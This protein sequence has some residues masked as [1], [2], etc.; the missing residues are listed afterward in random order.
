MS[1]PEPGRP[2]FPS[3][4]QPAFRIFPQRSY[5]PRRG[6]DPGFTPP[7]R[8]IDPGFTPPSHDFDPGFIGYPSRP[9]HPGVPWPSQLPPQWP[10][11]LTPP[12]DVILGLREYPQGVPAY[13][14]APSA[15]PAA[16]EY[17]APAPQY[18]EDP[19]SP[20]ARYRA[21][22]EWA[23]ARA[24][25]AS[26]AVSNTIE[27]WADNP[28]AYVDQRIARRDA[29]LAR[30]GISDLGGGHRVL[31]N[32]YGTGHAAPGGSGAPAQ[33]YQ[34]G[35]VVDLEASR[36]AGTVK[37]KPDATGNPAMAPRP[38]ALRSQI[39]QAQNRSA[40]QGQPAGSPSDPAFR[41]Q[42]DRGR[43][44]REFAGSDAYA[45]IQDSAARIRHERALQLD[46]A[47]KKDALQN[48]PQAGQGGAPA[49]GLPSSASPAADP[50][51]FPV[52]PSSAPLSPGSVRQGA[53]MKFDAIGL[54]VPDIGTSVGKLPPP[55]STPG[56]RL[57]Q[58]GAA[59]A[60]RQDNLLARLDNTPFKQASERRSQLMDRYNAR[61]ED[62][63]RR[64]G[65][66]PASLKA[67]E[68]QQQQQRQ[69][70]V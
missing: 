3:F 12:L 50:A 26:G 45:G 51:P 7:W 41:R 24:A 4:Q 62:A 36:A 28:G 16:P 8:D 66:V 34:D 13:L 49:G 10:Q 60:P 69:H 64:G 11:A 35:A 52:P 59:P 1:Y 61:R 53:R 43:M 29:E 33:F 47:R 57:S 18:T 17:P 48:T 38:D 23:R 27:A 39:Q 55:P 37:Y 25:A 22:E 30:D 31:V 14:P 15:E 6:I 2:T 67:W 5:D 19:N 20:A 63:Y 46:A 32:K 9:G 58:G 40:G 44:L 42:E 21:M 65:S 54:Q 70:P 56:P 68:K